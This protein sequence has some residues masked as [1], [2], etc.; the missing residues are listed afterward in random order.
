MALTPQEQDELDRLEQAQLEAKQAASLKSAL[1]KNAHPEWSDNNSW[2]IPNDYAAPTS[3]ADK[4]ASNDALAA[5]VKYGVPVA[6]SIAAPESIPLWVRMLGLGATAGGAS[7]AADKIQGKDADL[8]EAATNAVLMGTPLSKVPGAT[9]VFS[10]AA[11]MA[12]SSE[13]AQQIRS[14]IDSGKLNTSGNTLLPDA[15]SAALPVGSKAIGAALGKIFGNV[16]PEEAARVAGE[17]LNNANKDVVLAKMQAQGASVIPSSVN[18]SMKNQVLESI[19]GI[20]NVEG[21]VA[22]ANQPLANSIGRAEASMGADV[23]ITETSLAAARQKIADDSYALAKKHGFSDQLDNWRDATTK[24]KSAEKQ[25]NGGFTN[26]RGQA[27]DDASSDLTR[28]TKELD[29]AAKAAG[30]SADFDA[31]KTAFAKNY[32]VGDAV[33]SGTD[34]V[35]PSVL[36]GMLS[37]RGEG[38]L[39]GGLRDLAQFHNAFERS[40]KNPAKMATAPGATSAGTGLILGGG[41]PAATVGL[42]GGLPVVRRTIRDLLVSPSYQAKNAIRNYTPN[43]SSEPMSEAAMNRLMSLVTAHKMQQALTNNQAGR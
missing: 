24:L 22:R 25:L 1:P 43:T 11:R 3:P 19:A 13:T 8:G 37:Q 23:P 33:V 28:A 34:E 17:K 7:I 38:G 10:N 4:A 14:L 40:T 42:V 20:Q 12:L 29:K 27:V 21:G 26:A 32:D 9:G 6:A 35:R 2:H 15:I 16:A 30:V 5:T 41:N 31:A 18:P 36:S 39:S